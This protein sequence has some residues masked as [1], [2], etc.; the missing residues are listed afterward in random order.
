MTEYLKKSVL[1]FKDGVVKGNR[2][3]MEKGGAFIENLSSVDVERILTAECSPD[4]E[5]L[6]ESVYQS[7][8]SIKP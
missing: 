1:V 7:S 8:Q 2:E 6:I 4:E 5:I 3:R